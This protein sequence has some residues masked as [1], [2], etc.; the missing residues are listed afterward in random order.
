MSAVDA[1]PVWS[2]TC[3]TIARRHRILGLTRLHIRA[4]ADQAIDSGAKIVEAH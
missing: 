3:F 1:E 4:A 2:V